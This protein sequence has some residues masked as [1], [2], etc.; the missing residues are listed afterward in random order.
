M[1]LGYGFSIDGLILSYFL[2][3]L[4]RSCLIFIVFWVSIVLTGFG[5]GGFNE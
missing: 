1:G 3:I 4:G 5:G 2:L